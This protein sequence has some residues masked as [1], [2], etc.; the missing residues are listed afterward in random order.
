MGP[1]DGGDVAAPKVRVLLVEDHADTQRTLGRLLEA[2]GFEVRTAGSV[3]AARA[4]LAAQ[5]FDVVV[6]DIGLPDESGLDL[7]RHARS[8]YGTA[9]I[10]ISGF[11]TDADLKNSQEA[12]FSAHMTKPVDLAQLDAMI[13]V[14]AGP[15]PRISHPSQVVSGPSQAS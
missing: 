4:H 14:L 2:R 6:S 3:A 12:G 5:S 15:E 8:A 13:R 1:R 9:G 11:G 10:A 7:M